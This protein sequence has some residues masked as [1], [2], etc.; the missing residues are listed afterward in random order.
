ME[1]TRQRYQRLP[2]RRRGFIFGSSLWLGADHLL[3]VKSYRFREEYR[4]FYFADIQ[5][6]VSAAAPRF[7]ISTRSAAI[8]AVW[9]FVF[10]VAY[11]NARFTTFRT[12]VSVAGALLVLAWIYISYFRSCRCRIYTAVSSEALPSLYRDWTLRKFR[13]K[14]EPL[15]AEAQGPF[16]APLA[17]TIDD[18]DIGPLPEGRVGLA[19][20][21]PLATPV[22]GPPPIAARTPIS[23]LFVASLCLGGLANFAAL[24]ARP[25][26]GRWV[27]VG[28]LVLQLATAVAVM[29]QNYTGKLRASLRN[30]AIVTAVSIGV[31]YYAV[32]MSAGMA[33]AYR[34][35][36]VKNHPPQ[37]AIASPMTLLDYPA[38]RG[39]AGGIGVLAGLAGLLLLARG[40][41]PHEEKVSF[42][43]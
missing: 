23:V 9:L 26:V 8:G 25:S 10:L 11:V 41:R 13:E 18:H 38:S 36:T 32:Q 5:A 15:I 21:N 2:G 6:I 20:S 35:V 19:M 37:L 39:I 3:L 1:P 24:G 34:N 30:L 14:V 33:I 28:F 22:S 16:D 12:V 29:I 31:W 27:L 17:D 40:E 4:R 7:H 42:N 43:V